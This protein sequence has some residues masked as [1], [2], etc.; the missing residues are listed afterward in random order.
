MSAPTPRRVAVVGSGVAGLTA[1]YVASRSA[2]VTLFEADDRL[3][4]HADTH[5][6]DGLAIDTGFIVHNE[7]TYPTLLRLFRELGV[8]TQESEMSMSVRD[9][10][11]G[12]EWAGA[13]GLRG[14]FPGGRNLTRTSYLRML[15]D[16]PRFHRAARRLD[17]D[18]LTLRA[19][20]DQHGFSPYFRRHFMEP[21]VAAVWSCDP[22]VALDYPARYLFAFLEHHGMLGVKGSPTWRTVTGGSTSYV[23][24]VGAALDEVRTGTKVTSVLETPTGVEITDGNGRTTSYD[25]VVIATH[26]SQALAMLAAPTAAQRDVL[27][28][29]PYSPNVALL[30]TDVS[31]LPEATGARSSWNFRRPVED[32]GH[33]TVTYDLT[34]LQRLPTDTHYLV[35]LGGEH[36]VDPATVIDRMEYEHPLYTPESVAAQRRLPE[37]DT[38]RLVFAGAYHGWGFHEDGSR[39]GLA[40]VERLGLTWDDPRTPTTE[41]PAIYETTIRHTR[42]TPFKRAFTHRSHTW[43]V[44]LDHLPDRGILGRFEARDHLGEPGASIRANLARFLSSQGVELG[45]GRV[46]LAAH[47][48]AF[49]FCFN[50]IS[51]FW[52]WPE[53]GHPCS[54]VE[55]HNTYGDRH[56][57]LVHPD[58]QGRATTP[59]Q[60][61]VSPF[62][63]TDGTYDLAVPVPDDSLHVAVTLRTQD[64]AVFSASLSGRRSD[65]GPWR[66]APAALVGAL[67]IRVHGIVLWAR[68]LPIRP[69]PA[70]HQEGVR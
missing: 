7:R 19:F 51:V 66:A 33:V 9:D 47:P 29:I 64:G 45:S 68:R 4:G 28:A 11:T 36:L 53:Q 16:I 10:A 15:V 48:R 23:A 3:G 35:T 12:L 21:L 63:G 5:Q 17:D 62:H 52:V 14:L 69:R 30:H 42:R 22:A 46:L 55:V 70:H 31:L 61:Y 26:P 57:Y 54:V 25:A 59:K 41:A 40:A 38:D 43:L 67:L 2:H 56:A 65:H 18:E 24:R 39:S 44:D 1:A 6:V 20:L 49:G 58:E 60:M 8:A 34:R 37:L 13:L 32:L 27:S 50:P